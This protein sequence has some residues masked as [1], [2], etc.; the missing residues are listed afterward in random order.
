[1]IIRSVRDRTAGRDKGSEQEGDHDF[2]LVS[3]WMVL[4]RDFQM[5]GLL[6]VV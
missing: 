2:R 5:R 4:Y 6:A 3:C 1:M